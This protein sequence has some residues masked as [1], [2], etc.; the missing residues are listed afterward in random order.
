MKF[1]KRSKE[2]IAEAGLGLGFGYFVY[3]WGNAE[4]KNIAYHH[5]L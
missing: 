1:L 4:H 2:I 3:E 5:R